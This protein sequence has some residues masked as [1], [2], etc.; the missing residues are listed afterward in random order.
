MAI[1]LAQLSLAP[2]YNRNFV[3][4]AK[5]ILGLLALFTVV[6]Y[7]LPRRSPR[8][9]N[10][11]LWSAVGV[12]LSSLSVRYIGLLTSSYFGGRTGCYVALATVAALM[13]LPW[14]LF[15]PFSFVPSL[16][17]LA[18]LL[19]PEFGVRVPSAL[20]KDAEGIVS[21]YSPLRS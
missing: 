3:D 20:A 19:P 4:D 21:C 7:V 10:A 9:R 6:G 18:L 12:A 8:V 11:A 14:L 13:L 17:G 2:L 15:S 16:V 1:R 5:P